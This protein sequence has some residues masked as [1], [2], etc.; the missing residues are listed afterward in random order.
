[1]FVFANFLKSL[2]G[3]LHAAAESEVIRAS[4]LL[5][6]QLDYFLGY[7]YQ[8]ANN[9]SQILL[10]Q[11][12]YIKVSYCLPLVTQSFHRYSSQLFQLS[13]LC[14][15]LYIA[16]YKR[17]DPNSGFRLPHQNQDEIPVLY[18]D[19]IPFYDLLVQLLQYPTTIEQIL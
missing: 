5:L 1:M 13:G 17:A 7:F 8:I 10:C 19:K 2:T 15:L 14:F 4:T 16:S 9:H 12:I 18:M 6:L 3:N 11:D